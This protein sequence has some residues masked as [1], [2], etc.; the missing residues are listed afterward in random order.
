MSKLVYPSKP[1]LVIKNILTNE[2]CDFLRKLTDEFQE[3]K[4]PLVQLRRD[5]RGLYDV[6]PISERFNSYLYW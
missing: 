6:I 5:K 3:D 2:E 1:D 4:S